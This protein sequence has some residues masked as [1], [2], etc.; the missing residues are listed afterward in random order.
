MATAAEP[1]PSSTLDS[2]EPERA[3]KAADHAAL[4]A[5]AARE[6]RQQQETFAAAA[7]PMAKARGVPRAANLLDPHTAPTTVVNETSAAA[8]IERWAQSCDAASIGLVGPMRW[9]GL[10]VVAWRQQLDDQQVVTTLRFAPEITREALAAALG[11]LATKTSLTAA[12]CA[13]TVL[14]EL[15]P[16]EAGWSLTCECASP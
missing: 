13:H 4:S 16:S 1:P 9:R 12:H 14:R 11:S 6:S 2:F 7:V 15:R 8:A 10:E 5:A 3:E